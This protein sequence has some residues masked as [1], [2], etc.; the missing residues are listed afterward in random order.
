MNNT[1]EE[2]I[3]HLQDESTRLKFESKSISF[4]KNPSD[5]V[6]TLKHDYR[7]KLDN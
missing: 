1:I 4:M 7:I 6:Y 2:L 3:I 5:I